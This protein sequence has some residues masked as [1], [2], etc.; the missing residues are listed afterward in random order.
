MR[1]TGNRLEVPATAID[2]GGGDAMTYWS[3]M[4][5]L[6]ARRGLGALRIIGAG[7]CVKLSNPTLMANTGII[8]AC[9][10]G[11]SRLRVVPLPRL[12]RSTKHPPNEHGLSNVQRTAFQPHS[13]LGSA[14]SELAPIY[15][16]RRAR[17][18]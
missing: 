11:L 14:L 13:S 7:A 16:G 8:P 9:A 1:R 2:G 6:A 17:H 10:G 12:R 3:P 15:R 5:S 4:G 18:R